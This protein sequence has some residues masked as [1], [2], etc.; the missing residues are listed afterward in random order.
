MIFFLAFPLTALGCAAF[1][2]CSFAPPLRR[3]ALSSSLW[4]VACFPFFLAVAAGILAIVF[5]ADRLTSLLHRSGTLKDIGSHMPDWIGILI[6]ATIAII[7][8]GGATAVTLLH[9]ALIRRLT[10]ALFRL[11]VTCVS[12]GVGVLTMFFLLSAVGVGRSWAS[13]FINFVDII[14]ATL[15]AWFAY[16]KANQFRGSYPHRFPVVSREEFG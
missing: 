10:F 12:F 5:G 11:Y 14:P 4:F 7:T 3:F 2:I 1:V 16:R 9:G 13:L 15:L 8:F 6:A